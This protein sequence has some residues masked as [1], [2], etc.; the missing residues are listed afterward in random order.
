[1]IN[2]LCHGELFCAIIR[3][4]LGPLKP[5][6]FHQLFTLLDTVVPAA[7]VPAGTLVM[8]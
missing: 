8:G 3:P 4:D 1:M 5:Y 2:F 6:H 7:W